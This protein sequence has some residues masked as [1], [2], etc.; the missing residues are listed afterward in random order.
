MAPRSSRS[1]GAA[2]PGAA[3]RA[4]AATVVA[5]VLRERC[6]ADDALAAAERQVAE[7]DRALLGALVFGALRW[8]HRL[9]WQ[10]A[11]LL[12]KPLKPGQLELGAL[13]EVGLLQL[14]EMRI[15]EHAA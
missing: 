4:V 1:A 15:P 14:Q 8:H 11:R 6:D 7:R 9:L 2:R 12:T 5:R 3:V 10:S 13:L